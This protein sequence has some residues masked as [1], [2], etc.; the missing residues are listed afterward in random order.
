MRIVQN[1][2]YV[3]TPIDDE[4][5]A[6]LRK[7]TRYT[8]EK[9]E[10]GCPGCIGKRCIRWRAWEHTGPKFGRFVCGWRLRIEVPDGTEVR[11]KRAVWGKK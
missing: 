6:G 4:V 2:A 7:G 9:I 8:P 5:W 10:F 3:I 1:R 11:W